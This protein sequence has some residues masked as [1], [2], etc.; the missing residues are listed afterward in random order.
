[1]NDRYLDKEINLIS[2]YI[3]AQLSPAETEKVKA[4]LQTDPQLNQLFRDLSYTHKLLQ[5]LPHKRAP[6]NFTLTPESV[7]TKR[8]KLW[9]QPALSL[10]S[11]AAA[12]TLVVVFGYNFLSNGTK[13]AAPEALR[14][15]D[16]LAMESPTEGNPPPIIN[17]NGAYGM[18]GGGSDTYA[19]GLGGGGAA[20]TY[21]GGIGGGGAGGSGLPVTVP[22]VTSELAPT[23]MPAE[24]LPMEPAPLPETTIGVE[25][26]PLTA[27]AE[28]E[29]PDAA[30]KSAGESDLSSLILGI[31]EES[32]QGEII[33][34]SSRQITEEQPLHK[35][36]PTTPV[37]IISG[38]IAALAGATALILRKR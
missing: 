22:E 3:D 12:V 30:A 6:R 16:L 38:I 11:V 23:E 5:A 10:V 37:M 24:A 1:M 18:G 32:S 26:A 14:S 34:Y 25:E 15:S 29:N 20:D 8:F 27:M 33:D 9:L 13:Q 7:P 17:W 21:T 36:F 28:P 19:Y 31:P 35:P 4:R 2:A